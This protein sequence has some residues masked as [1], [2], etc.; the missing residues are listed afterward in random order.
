MG[1]IE[2]IKDKI[3]LQEYLDQNY[4]LRFKKAGKGY[5]CKCP[6]H[7]DTG[8]KTQTFH[9]DPYKGM[10]HCFSC[11]KGG[12]IFDF[13]MFKENVPFESVLMRLAG[14]L[15]LNL[16]NSPEWKNQQS[17]S[18]SNQLIMERGK[19][20]IGAVR[21][22]LVLKRGFTDKTIDEFDL[23]YGNAGLTIGGVLIPEGV[24]FPIKDVNRRVIAFAVRQDT[25]PKYVNNVNNA[26][27]IKLETLY[28]MDK[29][30][31][32]MYKT[33]SLYVVE[34]YTDAISAHQQGQES[35][36]GMACVAYCGQEISIDQIRLIQKVAPN[37][38]MNIFLAPDNDE[39]GK[40]HI[41]KIRERFINFAPKCNVRVVLF[42]QEDCT[43]A[44]GDVRKIKDFNDCLVLGILIADLPTEHIDLHCLKSDLSTCVYIEDEFMCVREF[45][46]Q[47][48]NKMILI[49][50]AKYLAGRWK[51]KEEDVLDFF[52]I[53]S[54]TNVADRFKSFGQ[55]IDAHRKMLAHSTGLE[56]GF[57]EID[58]TLKG[59][60]RLTDVI[61]IGSPPSVG[62]TWFAIETALH[63][64]RQ[65]K[66]VLFISL[67][68]D[69]AGLF[70]RIL[71]NLRGVSVD[72][73]NE[74]VRQ[75]LVDDDT[76]IR[77]FDKYLKV[78]DDS[79]M[80][81]KDIEDSLKYA[82]TVV[83]EGEKVD[84][85]IID[86]LQMM[87]GVKKFEDLEEVVVGLKT[88]IA[89]PF[90]CVVLALSQMNREYKPWVENDMSALKGTGAL[91]ATGD[92]IMTMW[93]PE[94][95]PDITLAEKQKCAD[96]IEMKI[97]KAR[98]GKKRERFTLKID[99]KKTRLEVI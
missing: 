96:Q 71:A 22:Y 62:K 3:N 12:T 92:I 14:E 81:L 8:D 19:A 91:E 27:Y 10:F 55:G 50:L 26:L 93:K 97:G 73:H 33:N 63:F 20:K 54:S 52:N 98:R 30:K 17:L 58:A 1:L 39:T 21:D 80:S 76:I 24:L 48:D 57:P 66:R 87:Q 60:V 47:I 83:F 67:E 15:N 51:R 4:K 40:R 95:N 99:Y 5:T 84:L 64:I 94:S 16:A 29:A 28:N 44:N 78:I 88:V 90:N 38:H 86:Y 32:I 82:N 45:V 2:T 25:Q 9:V 18:K 31:D 49:D 59:G 56:L 89:K 72:E 34:G 85:V 74:H 69:M 65:K 61:L 43:F 79:K 36:L 77:Q 70:E 6:L 35:G 53:K 7:V 23:G 11:S 42:P 13:I 37:P 41:I 46:S 68:M 75:G